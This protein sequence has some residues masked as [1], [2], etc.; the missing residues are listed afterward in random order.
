MSCGEEQGREGTERDGGSW[1]DDVLQG[2]VRE[3]HAQKATFQQ[4]PEGG[5]QELCRY[6]GEEHQAERTASAK[7]LRQTGLPQLRNMGYVAGVE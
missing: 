6:L 4:R 7:A 2:M 5:Q 1:S 3:G